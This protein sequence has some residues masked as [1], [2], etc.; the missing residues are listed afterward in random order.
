MTAQQQPRQS[1]TH[2]P[3]AKGGSVVEQRRI[4]Y[5]PSLHQ[6]TCRGAFH[7]RPKSSSSSDNGGGYKYL[8]NDNY[9]SKNKSR[10]NSKN[11]TAVNNNN[12]DIE[13]IIDDTFICQGMQS[14]LRHVADLPLAYNREEAMR[15]F[16]NGSRFIGEWGLNNNNNIDHWKQQ[17]MQKQQQQ[18]RIL[19]NY[20]YKI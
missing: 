4:C 16:S 17:Q 2:A 18:P 7:V 13:T 5:Q 8:N 3:M 14:K 11:E 9:D 6:I 10:T 1:S 12:V 19:L 20:Y 15:Q